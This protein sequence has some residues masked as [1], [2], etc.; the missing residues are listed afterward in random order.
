[1]RANKFEISM[2]TCPHCG[3]N[4]PIPRSK[5]M[6]R[7]RNHI[8]DLYCIKCNERVKMMETRA[9]DHLKTLSG[10]SLSY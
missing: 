10:V 5:S 1:M 2:F 6:R 7:E 3:T 4:F 8:K 9:K